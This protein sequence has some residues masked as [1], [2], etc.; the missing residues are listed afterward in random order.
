MGPVE[1]LPKAWNGICREGGWNIA[2]DGWHRAR[3]R[4]HDPSDTQQSP[5]PSPHT[6][7]CSAF[8]NNFGH[9][10][11]SCVPYK[12]MTPNRPEGDMPLVGA[13]SGRLNR[14]TGGG[15]RETSDCSPPLRLSTP[16]DWR[17]PTNRAAFTSIPHHG[18]SSVCREFTRPTPSRFRSMPLYRTPNLNDRSDRPEGLQQAIPHDAKDVLEQPLV[19]DGRLRF[20]RRGKLYGRTPR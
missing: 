15:R 1:S 17:G 5:S 16:R 13:N 6:E 9:R 4:T 14:S 7:F 8:R 2:A 18:T 10:R 20:H 11:C 12:S 19:A 3:P